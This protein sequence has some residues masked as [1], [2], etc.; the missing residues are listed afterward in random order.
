MQPET[1]AKLQA[2]EAVDWFWAAGQP[3]PEAIVL[4]SWPEAIARATSDDWNDVLMQAAQD[5]HARLRQLS[6]E[7]SERWN[8]ISETVRPSVMRLV[9]LKIERLKADHHLPRGFFNIVYWDI[10]TYAMELEYSDV[11][12]MGFSAEQARWYLRGHFPCGRQGWPLTGRP[13]VY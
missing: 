7:R 5:Y 12:P 2:L 4:G 11:C 6:R 13:I 10:L 1:L 8:E 9:N 3:D